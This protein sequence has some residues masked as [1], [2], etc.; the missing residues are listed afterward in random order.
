MIEL[1]AS[2]YFS[3][4]ENILDYLVSQCQSVEDLKKASKPF[5]GARYLFTKH[6]FGKLF[7]ST[8]TVASKPT[9]DNSDT[10][11]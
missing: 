7:V 6:S 3:S 10:M 4:D 1:Y 9:D 5:L 2:C 8:E 11:L